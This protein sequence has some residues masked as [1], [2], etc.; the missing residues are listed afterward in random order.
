MTRRV[1]AAATHLHFVR[2]G[3]STWNAAGRVQGSYRGDDE[4]VLT[5]TGR[6]QI[7]EAGRQVVGVLGLPSG[8][9]TVDLW[10][11]DLARARESAEVLAVALRPMGW[12]AI[13]H[14]EPAWRE[15][16]L[17]SMEGR[18]AGSLVAE[19]P[20]EG[21]HI[22]EIR[23]GGGESLHDVHE[24]VGAWLAPA[25]AAPG[26]LVVVSH[27]HTIRAA[28]AWLRGRTWRDVDWDE[29]VTPGSVTT[30]VLGD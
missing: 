2:H 1:G 25:L 12:R 22:S 28:L 23:W 24:R 10:S 21:R 4:P 17:G 7:A 18:S 3:E 29:P 16:H 20:G 15:Q 14:P 27:E 19:E 8:A 9:R 6:Q 5:A 30:V 13:V 11:S 26:H